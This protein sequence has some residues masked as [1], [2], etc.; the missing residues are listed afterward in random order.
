M[1]TTITIRSAEN[2]E[3]T[4]NMSSI[5]LNT[6]DLL[7][8]YNNTTTVVSNLPINNTNR[9][10]TVGNRTIQRNI[11]IEN[12]STDVPVSTEQIA[13]VVKLQNEIVQI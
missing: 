9:P 6:N 2:Q 11:A 7:D 12:S 8:S 13:N 5:P 4:L 1:V 10:I 3:A